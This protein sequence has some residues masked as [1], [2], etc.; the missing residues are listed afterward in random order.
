MLKMLMGFVIAAALCCGCASRTGTVTVGSTS[1]SGDLLLLPV[2]AEMTLTE[3]SGTQTER[4]DWAREAETALSQAVMR[5][6]QDAG[7]TVYPPPENWPSTGMPDTL[8][9][10]ERVLPMAAQHVQEARTPL[11]TSLDIS[12]W[13]LGPLSPPEAMPDG[14]LVLSLVHKANL[15]SAGHQIAQ[16]GL[17]AAF[18]L[19]TWPDAGAQTTYA[20]LV[21]PLTGDLVWIASFHGGDPRSITG[22]HDIAAQLV[23]LLSGEAA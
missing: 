14:T 1:P 12:F 3:L 7:Y 11:A 9:L 16:I 23:S 10:V 4:A 20:A 2:R 6:L 21:E 22:A 18:A 19:P 13:S 8:A 17:S 5:V 15:T